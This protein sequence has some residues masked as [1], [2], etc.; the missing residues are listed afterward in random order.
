MLEQEGFR[1]ADRPWYGAE[2]K[3]ARSEATDQKPVREI[4]FDNKGQLLLDSVDAEGAAAP[5]AAL[6]ERGRRRRPAARQ[7]G[8]E[9]EG[10]TIG[11]KAL[12]D[13]Q[14]KLRELIEEVQRL[15]DQLTPPKG[16]G[17][18]LRQRIE[19][20]EVK[21]T[22]ADEELAIIK[23]LLVN[24]AVESELSCGAARCW[25]PASRSWA[26]SAWRPGRNCR[27]DCNGR[28]GKLKLTRK[29][30]DGIRPPH[31]LGDKTASGSHSGEMGKR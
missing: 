29:G 2:L 24:T 12:A 7:P 19:D 9:P 17:K 26:A 1:V 25:R 27:D 6:E 15:T 30:T 20:R 31:L 13:E 16:K 18:G 4:V 23:P 8:G 5:P 28:D 10:G 14:V 22:L 11:I 21:V 3:H